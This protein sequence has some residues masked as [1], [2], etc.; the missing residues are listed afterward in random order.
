MPEADDI[1][2]SSTVLGE[3]KGG[4]CCLEVEDEQRK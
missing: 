4:D 1:A 3:A 2:K